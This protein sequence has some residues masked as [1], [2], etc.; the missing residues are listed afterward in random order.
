[1]IIPMQNYILVE[2][3]GNVEKVLPSGII[4]PEPKDPKKQFEGTI[5]SIGPLI[6]NPDLKA[7]QRVAINAYG[8]MVRRQEGKKEFVLIRDVDVI[9]LLVGEE[10]DPK[11]AFVAESDSHRDYM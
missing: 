8:V 1:M 9:A 5:V 11:S 7:G 2:Q 4:I 6:K 3:E 10:Y